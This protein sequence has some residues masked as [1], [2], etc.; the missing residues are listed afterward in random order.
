MN[1]GGLA[2]R[3]KQPSRQLRGSD[4]VADEPP[5]SSSQVGYVPNFEASSGL[6]DQIEDFFSA[7]FT[8]ALIVSRMGTGFHGLPNCC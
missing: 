2:A 5:P 4:F 1:A 6:R 7:D 8:S 3:P